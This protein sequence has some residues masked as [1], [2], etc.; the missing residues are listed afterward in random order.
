MQQFQTP[1]S[2]TRRPS[3]RTSARTSAGPSN[4]D[5]LEAKGLQRGDSGKDVSR[6]QDQLQYLGF[7]S[8]DDKA[9]GHGAFGGRTQNAVSGFEGSMGEGTVADGVADKSTRQAITARLAQQNQ[10]TVVPPPLMR[11]AE[12]ERVSRLQAGLFGLGLLNES[13]YTNQ[14]GAYKGKTAKAVETLQKRAGLPVTGNMDAGSWRVLIDQAGP[15]VISTGAEQ[16]VRLTGDPALRKGSEGPLVR[17]LETF[18]SWW[19]ADIQP[20][21]VFD[22]D[23]TR[24]VKSF[25]QANQLTVDGKANTATVAALVSGQ[26]QSTGGSGGPAT[27]AIQSLK[28]IKQ[29]TYEDAKNVILENNGDLFVDGDV[30]ILALRTGN[31][32]TINFEDYFIVL[33][34]NG[35]METFLAT[36]RPSTSKVDPS[37]G[38]DPA[39]VLAG[40]Y[41]LA[42]RWSTPGSYTWETAFLVKEDGSA[43]KSG[44]MG[45]TVAKDRNQD[46]YFSEEERANPILDDQIRAHRGSPTGTTFSWGC[47]TVLDFDGFVDFIG[48]NKV[49]ADL[50]IVDISKNL[51]NR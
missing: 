39:M 38:Q 26:A 28:D 48:S 9:T 10:D 18:L 51:G 17:E 21:D 7:L 25:Q 36:T 41:D 43:K 33:K 27:Q 5:A 23:T 29:L 46:G 31:N 42:E 47:L 49:P 40:N 19:G 24:A 12:G 15:E 14:R 6:L 37:K 13:T 44:G 11:G 16:G 30:T 32:A 45:V 4:T 1:T 3:P 20:D 35:D 22:G 2:S 34:K 50:C 8:A